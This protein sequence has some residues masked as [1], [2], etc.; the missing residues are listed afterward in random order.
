MIYT[1]TV[2]VRFSQKLAAAKGD[3]PRITAVL[4]TALM[5]ILNSAARAHPGERLSGTS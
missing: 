2:S 4:L 3:E 1:N 5:N